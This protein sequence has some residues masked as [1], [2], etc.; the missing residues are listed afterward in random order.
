LQGDDPKYVLALA[1]AKH[2][3]VHS[4]PEALRHVFDVHPSERDLYETYLPQFEAA[5]REGH[6]GAVMSAYNS[7]NGEP[8]ASSTFLLTDVLR[9]RWNFD[10]QVVSDCDAVA[11]IWR[12]HRTVKTAAEAAA[13]A[14]KGGTDLCCGQTYNNLL[15][16]VGSN[17]ITV[18]E[19]DTALGRILESRF[20]LGLF[21]PSNTVPYLQ[22]TMAENDT[23]EHRQL[24]LQMSRES[25]VLLKNDGLLPLNRSK[26]KRIAV[27]GENATNRRMLYGNYNGTPSS[28]VTILDGIRAVA[29]T[30]IDVSYAQGCPLIVRPAGSPTGGG[31][32]FGGPGGGAPAPTRP[33]PELQSEAL[34]NAA[35]AEILVYVGGIN[36]LLEGEEGNARGAGG[37]EGFSNGDRTRIELPQVQEDFIHA[38]QATGKPVILINCS[39]SAMAMPWEAEHLPAILQ[40]WYPGEEGGRA[41]AET[42]FGDNNPAGR[43]PITFYRSTTELPAFTNYS[44]ANRTYRYFTGTPL[45]SFGHGL[46]YTHFT[47]SRPSLSSKRVHADGTIAVTF[48]VQNAGARDGDEVAQVYFAHGNSTVPQPIKALCAFQRVH[49]PAGKTVKVA[50]NIPA[51]RLRYWDDTKESYTVDPGE[52]HLL[53]GAASDDIR[54]KVPVSVTAQ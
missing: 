7:V 4:G 47:Y 8:A 36:S 11:D 16:A 28:A 50:I 27:F 39:G 53:I 23:P 26:V 48:N 42:L 38:L 13:R 37:V 3:A 29:G 25:M 1:C 43:L 34:S 51:E 6:V 9:H 22:I 31:R 45:Y 40:A 30:N 20:K 10:G 2:Y 33:L 35:N 5:V 19:V 21:D 17:Y 52:Y 49:V 14:V 18:A 12:N 32:G 24:A 41:V 54:L 15:A 46:S 44:M